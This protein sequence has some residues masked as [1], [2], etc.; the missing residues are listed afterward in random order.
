KI[1]TVY[2]ENAKRGLASTTATYFLMSG[3]TGFPLAA[4][5]GHA[6]TVWRTAAA[7][8][9]ASKFLSRAD[10]SRLL[11]VG[12]GSLAPYLARAHASVRPITEVAI[13]NRTAARAERLA[14]RLRAEGLNA[15]AITGLEIAVRAADVISCAT[16]STEPLI[17]G[18]WLKEGAHL[19][20]VGGFTP[21]MREADD[22]AAA[23]ARIYV[24]TCAALTEAGDIA[25]PLQRGKLRQADIQGDLSELCQ[26]KVKGRASAREITLFKSVGSAIEDLAAAMLLWEEKGTG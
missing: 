26:N 12:A 5:D 15:K 20:L 16:L 14:A 25:V 24:D 9:L 18:D 10:A 22:Q 23:R 13:W 1:L 11:I 4:L 8:A 3:E 17:R 21:A 19:D 2:P 7:S 6:L